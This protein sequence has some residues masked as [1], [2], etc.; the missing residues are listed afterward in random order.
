MAFACLSSEKRYGLYVWG[1][2]LDKLKHLHLIGWEIISSSQDR[3]AVFHTTWYEIVVPKW[4]VW[5]GVAFST[6]GNGN[7]TRS[8]SWSMTW[9]SI[10]CIWWIFHHAFE[11]FKSLFIDKRENE[12]L[13]I[14]IITTTRSWITNKPQNEKRVKMRVDEHV[15]NGLGSWGTINQL[16]SQHTKKCKW[17]YSLLFLK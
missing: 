7:V 17:H 6:T 11:W 9:A 12:R 14:G 3:V 16:K 5:I 15:R 4:C 10:N 8:K 13:V 2:D 1:C